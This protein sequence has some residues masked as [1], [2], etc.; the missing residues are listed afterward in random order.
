VDGTPLAL[1]SRPNAPVAHDG[2]FVWDSERLWR[3][4]A[5]AVREVVAAL[6]AEPLGVAVT[7]FGADGAPFSPDG[8]QRYPIISWHD[9]RTVDDLAAIVEQVGERRLYELTGYHAYP[10]NTLCKWRWLARNE[11]DALAGAT[12]LMV[13]DVVA[14]RLCGERRTDPTSASTTMAFDLAAGEWSSQLLD[15]IGVP[16]GLPAPVTLPGAP[17]GE[18]TAAAAA[19]TGLPEGLPV[20]AAGHD[21]EIVALAAGTLPDGTA[22][23]V[24]GTWEIVMIRHDRFQP[25]DA[26]FENG[27]VWEVD[28]TP[29]RY[30]CLALMPSGSVVNWLRDVAYGAD[31]GALIAEATSAPIGAHG[32]TVVPAFVRGMGPYGRTANGGSFEGLQTTT[33]RADLARAV[34]E[35]LC[36]QLRSQLGVLERLHVQPFERLRVCGGAQKNPF[37][38]QLKADTTGCVA[39]AVEHEEL[40]LLGAALLAGVG[41]GVYG[42]VD[43]AVRAAER[44][45]RAIEPE[46]V[47]SAAYREL[48]GELLPA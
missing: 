43:E 10:I 37:W 2:G 46:P 31:Y 22:L 15:E 4:I 9:T 5:S 32:V 28:A 24:S 47:A 7:G 13:P 35:A 42:S 8:E 17:V 20:V 18:V 40:T 16:A 25:E 41:A 11:P 36:L 45:P 26:F 23:D 48:F 44:P 12:W 39:E 3:D 21:A 34:F 33:T 30:L 29:G 38:M 14:F 1:A 6:D 19:Q 27:I